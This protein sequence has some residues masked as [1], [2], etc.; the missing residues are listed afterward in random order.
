MWYF[1]NGGGFMGFFTNLLR[2]SLR[3]CPEGYQVGGVNE[4]GFIYYEKIKK[5]GEP[6]KL[7]YD[8]KEVIM[9]QRVTTEDMLKFHGI[10]YKLNFP[11]RKHLAKNS[12]PF[13]YMDL[14]PYNQE[15][16]KKELERL[17]KYIVQA[18]NY[19]PLLTSEYHIDVK[20]V[21]LYNY[22]K[23]YGYTRLM[24]T[25][26]TFTGKTSKYPLSLYFMSRGDI[27]TYS[28]NGEL[29][30]NVDGSWGK[31]IVNVGKAPANYSRPGTGWTFDFSTFNGEFVLSTAKTTLRP[32]QYG[33]ATIV[34]RCNQIIKE[35]K[36]RALNRAIFEWFQKNLPDDCPK[37]I[38]GFSRMRNAN[39][40]NY[41]AI[42][43][44]AEAA[45]FVFPE[46]LE[47]VANWPE[48]Q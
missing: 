24:C 9:V 19:I 38:G 43:K 28:V 47:D 20:K 32:D 26:H 16:A 46:T 8:Q 5:D 14:D 27:R 30:Y 34:Y 7:S 15:I 22:S 21:M 25:P 39:S 44:K 3:K 1:V 6:E 11:I 2:S 4:D 41:Q 33:M 40:K 45:G 36:E 29:F 18:R 37:T 23:D 42:V 31:A 13:A 35:E 48:N 12:H 17:D 10:P